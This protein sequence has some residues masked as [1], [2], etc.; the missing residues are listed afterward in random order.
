MRKTVRSEKRRC[1]PDAPEM[2]PAQVQGASHSFAPVDKETRIWTEC[3]THRNMHELDQLS[4]LLMRGRVRKKRHPRPRSTLGVDAGKHFRA[5][6]S[7]GNVAHG[8][9]IEFRKL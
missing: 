2:R 4:P 1:V 5:R 7:W 3:I 9:A 8:V 6:S